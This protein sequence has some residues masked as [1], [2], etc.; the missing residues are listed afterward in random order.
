MEHAL[1]LKGYSTKTRKS[2][3]GH[4]ERLARYLNLNLDAISEAEIHHYLLKLLDEQQRSHSYVNAAVSATKFLLKHVLKKGHI[5]VDLPRP[6]KQQKLP[7]V[8]SLDDVI[9]ILEAVQN[10]K[11]RSIL[12]V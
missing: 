4:V 11:H 10:I 9:R 1:K 12:S 5:A 7:S 3:I 2:Y 6:K 8:L